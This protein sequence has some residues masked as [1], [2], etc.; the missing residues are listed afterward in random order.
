[1]T[2]TIGYRPV[3][4]A[5]ERQ[6]RLTAWWLEIAPTRQAELLMVPPPPM[7]WLG[8]SLELAGLEVDDVRR[9]LDSERGRLEATRD[10]GVSPRPD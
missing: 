5:D 3:M 4:D 6:N 2:P 1:M 10:A 8:E 7:P 9:F